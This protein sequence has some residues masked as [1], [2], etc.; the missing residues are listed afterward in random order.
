[1]KKI[2]SK[3]LHNAGFLLSEV[4]EKGKAKYLLPKATSLG[5]LTAKVHEGT[6]GVIELLG[7]L[8]VRMVNRLYN[9][10]KLKT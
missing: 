2:K 8:L 9:H 5:G 7:I 1:M 4:L 10:Q 6:L 3:I